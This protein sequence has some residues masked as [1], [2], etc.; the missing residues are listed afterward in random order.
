MTVLHTINYQPSGGSACAAEITGRDPKYTFAREFLDPVDTDR[1]S[2]GRTG[3][4]TYE[5][6]EGKI[7]QVK[8]SWKDK[9]FMIVKDNQLMKIGVKEALEIVDSQ[10][11]P[12]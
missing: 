4:N 2:S 6:H 10:G 3:S 7:Y 1:S 5:L 8:P 11:E 9:Y 12:S